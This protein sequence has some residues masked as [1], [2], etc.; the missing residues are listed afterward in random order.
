MKIITHWLTTVTTY[1]ITIYSD[2]EEGQCI[3]AF[4]S[5]KAQPPEQQRASVDE[6]EQPGEE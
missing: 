3:Q 6:S 1:S 2:V 5:K 4:V